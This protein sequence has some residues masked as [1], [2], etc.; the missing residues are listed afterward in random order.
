[1]SKLG[2]REPR[3][4][5]V[6]VIQRGLRLF[7]AQSELLWRGRPTDLFQQPGDLL[8]G[9]HGGGDLL[10]FIPVVDHSLLQRLEIGCAHLQERTL[11][12]ND[13]VGQW[14]VKSADARDLGLA[15]WEADVRQ[16]PGD[17]VSAQTAHDVV[18]AGGKD[19]AQAHLGPVE[20][21][22]TIFL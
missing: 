8:R 10:N 9:R 14:T 11:C 12:E 13:L 15:V 5:V 17:I 7:L 6:A 20:Q 4:Q 18:A 3:A 22:R 16:T 2:Y 19:G 1:M 21:R